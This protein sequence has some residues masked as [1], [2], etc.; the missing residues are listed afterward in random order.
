MQL[1]K[2]FFSQ[3]KATQE[4]IHPSRFFHFPQK[5]MWL[6]LLLVFCTGLLATAE[7]ITYPPIVQADP[8][9]ALNGNPILDASL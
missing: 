3:R 2:V 6:V 7:P 5:K 1:L 8:R 4:G 9:F